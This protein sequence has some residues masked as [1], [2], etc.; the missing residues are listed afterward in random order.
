MEIHD[1][2]KQ[3]FQDEWKKISYRNITPFLNEVEDK[4][5]LYTVRKE[6]NESINIS[7]DK[8]LLERYHQNN[9]GILA[10]L[11]A[12]TLYDVS[13]EGQNINSETILEAKREMKATK[14]CDAYPC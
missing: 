8:G 13:N 10:R 4:F 5:Y 6:V 7:R 2:M 9:L 14:E 12:R 3:A 11:Y 1:L